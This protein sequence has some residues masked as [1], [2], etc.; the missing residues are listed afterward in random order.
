MLI[1]CDFD[2]TVTARDT[3]SE[4]ARRFAPDR[5]AAIEG[6]LA[7]REVSVRETL[8]HEFEGL[9]VPLDALVEVALEVP[10]RPGFRVLVEQTRAAGGD[11]ILLS[12]GFRQIIEPILEREGM[13]GLVQLLAND[14]EVGP[15][16]ARIRWRELPMC[17][18]CD[19]H[20]KRHEVAQLRTGLLHDGRRFDQ[21]VFVGDGFSDRCGADVADRIFARDS[22]ATWLDAQGVAWEAWDDFH[23]IVAALELSDSTDSTGRT[24]PA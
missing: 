17:D 19:E 23:D 24:T 22:L 5:Y 18:I 13:A 16:G 1:V 12:S 21:L 14:I 2:G 7:R 10:V 15:D 3:N 20:C 4:L 9:G 6:K 8:A 11:V